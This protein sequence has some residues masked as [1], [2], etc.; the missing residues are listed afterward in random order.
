MRIKELIKTKLTEGITHIE[1]LVVDDFI[2]K[3]RNIAEYIATEKL[4][5]SN[6]RVGFD[7]NGRMFTSR[8][9]KKGERYYTSDDYP[10]KFWTTGFRSFHKA[11][12]TIEDELKKYIPNGS[13]AEYEVLFGGQPNTIPYNNDINYAVFIRPID[14]NVDE[15][16]LKNKTFDTSIILD[17]TPTTEDGEKISYEIQ[18]H[19]WVFSSTPDI[20]RESYVDLLSDDDIETKIVELEKIISKDNIYEKLPTMTVAEL[21][22]LPLNKKPEELQNENWKEIKGELKQ[23]KEKYTDII[24]NL[25]LDVKSKVIKNVINKV[26]SKFGPSI[27]DGGWIEGIVFRHS[28]NPDDQFKVVDK[29]TFTKKNKEVWLVRK[30]VSNI[31]KKMF[32]DIS[33]IIGHTQ[34]ASSYKNKYIQS[35]DN[36]EDMFDIAQ[37]KQQTLNTITNTI[38]ELKSLMKEYITN[39]DKNSEIDK[40]NK[41]DFAQKIETLNNLHKFVSKTNTVKDFIKIFFLKD[42]S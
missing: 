29:D 35:I 15:N 6:I 39:P 5:G 30:N 18:Q 23:L 11:C 37:V 7:D 20:D 31:I 13:S 10:I 34:I 38:N 1:E 36:I 19:K 24:Q 32:K 25:K 22:I 42:L 3:V 26:S 12:Q 28:S 17:K 4:D 27:E 2:E 21:L 14:N 33:N 40:R 9:T 41:Q 16:G 8:E